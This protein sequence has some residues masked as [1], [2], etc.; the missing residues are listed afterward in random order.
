MAKRTRRRGQRVRRILLIVGGVV[1]VSSLVAA[2]VV[3]TVVFAGGNRTPPAATAS[4]QPTTTGAFTFGGTATTYTFGE[5]ATTLPF[6]ERM[7]IRLT[8]DAIRFRV[9]VANQNLRLGEVIPGIVELGGIWIGPDAAGTTGE[10]PTGVLASPSV[11]IMPATTLVDG[12]EYTGPWIDDVR[13]PLGADQFHAVSVA[14]SFDAR[15]PIATTFSGSWLTGGETSK[16]RDTEPGE[17]TNGI[18]LLDIWIEYEYVGH[19]PTMLVYGSSLS[20]PGNGGPVETYGEPAAWPQRWAESAGG[21]AL[22]SAVSTGTIDHFVALNRL[23]Q[24]FS[25]IVP[26]AIVLWT[27]SNSLGR[28]DPYDQVYADTQATIDRL[29]LRYPSAVIVLATEPGRNDFVIPDEYYQNRMRYNEW[30]RSIPEGADGY[31]DLDALLSDPSDNHF[32]SEEYDS[33]DL[34]H[35]NEAGHIAVAEL[36]RQT[37]SDLGV[38]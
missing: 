32:L 14:L 36:V 21:I 7:P 3:F 35:L 23:T 10:Y 27:A 9:H 17:W 20:T 2:L 15:Q 19:A 29:R 34:V 11:S 13:Y 33:G 22:N 12:A 38:R 5:E 18:S 25:D 31:I 1:L 26:D 30:I 28:G 4:A 16:A 8:Q 6:I 24:R 37:L